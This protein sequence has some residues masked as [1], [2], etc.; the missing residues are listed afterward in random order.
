VGN[1]IKAKAI[2][3][4]L[5]APLFMGNTM[6][7]IS[8][9]GGYRL[10]KLDGH[11]VKWGNS[12]LGVGAT[13]SY[14]FVT[15]PRRFENA[16][17]CGELVPMSDLVAQHG[18]SQLALEEQTATAFR[19]WE[20]AAN[21]RFVPSQDPDRADILIGAQANPV[22]RAFANVEYGPDG[23][24]GVKVIQQALVCLNPTQRWKVGFDGDLDAYDLRYTL[25]HEIGHAIGLD[26][27]GPSGQVMSFRY[28]E[29][30]S[31]LQPG[32]F[33]G[34]QRIYGVSSRNLADGAGPT[35]HEQTARVDTP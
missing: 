25:I 31:D 7:P 5:V 24:D 2:V 20:A 14:A 29:R 30:H 19:V 34:A 33:I 12:V 1:V 17:N 11:H 9:T 32:D 10:L 22:G 4:S 27:P 26:H 28:D 8:D 13:V 23:V 3:L 15:T 18:V 35:Q 16:R 6:P 21:I